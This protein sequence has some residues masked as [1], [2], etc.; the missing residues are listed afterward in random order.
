MSAGG[1][2]DNFP[3]APED[4]LQHRKQEKGRKKV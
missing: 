2:R 4:F 1:V 3:T